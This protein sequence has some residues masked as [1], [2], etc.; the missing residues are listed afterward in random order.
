MCIRDRSG[1]VPSESVEAREL[2]TPSFN[3]SLAPNPATDKVNIKWD[4]IH[5]GARI[6]IAITDLSGKILYQKNNIDGIWPQHQINVSGFHAGTY[7]LSMNVN[8]QV[9]SKNIQ[10]IR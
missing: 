5:T 6:K 2:V 10:I 3:I 7:V 1:V 9:V 4:N 8:G